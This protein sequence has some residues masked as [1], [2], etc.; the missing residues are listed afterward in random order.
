MLR[1]LWCTKG[2]GPGGAER[3]LVS[4]ARCHDR[5]RFEVE[6]AYVLPWKDHLVEELTDLDVAVHCL[7]DRHRGSPMWILRLARLL[8]R[9]RY[10]VVHLHSP[11]MAVAVRL[12]LLLDRSG[13]ATVSTQHNLWQ[14]FRFPTRWANRLT[15]GR[16][17]HVV[18][19]ADTVRESMG[20][21]GASTEVIVHGVP[22]DELRARAGDGAG[23]RHDIDVADGVP[24]LCTV[25]NLRA[26]KAYPDLL[27]A[28]RIVLDER[29][30]VRF[31]AVGQGPLADEL[32]AE[33]QRL[34]L[35]DGFRVLGYRPDAVELT[36]AA[37]LFVLS[38]H[39]EGLPVAVMESLAVGTPVVSTDAGGVTDAVRDRIEGRIVPVAH[40]EQLAATILDVLA[41]GETRQAM[42]EA[43][44]E[45]G[46]AFSIEGAVRRW[47]EIYAEA[48][49]R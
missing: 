12:L 4:A 20:S 45:R 42:A 40:P 2:L 47:E 5:E 32:E 29:P 8:R 37:D 19:V 14:S 3:L 17:Q 11:V 39:H 41:D 1:V 15:L 30:E 18:A 23:T 6:V 28:A 10:D 33:R 36:A 9:E 25:A 48:A 24:L 49:D 16:D 44:A 46:A 26:N 27:A 22:L 34:D 38:S 21:A 13:P 31:V 35:G 7:G 43:A